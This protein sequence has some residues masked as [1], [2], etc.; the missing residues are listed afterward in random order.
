M[1]YQTSKLNV[2]RLAII[3]H[4]NDNW[5]TTNGFADEVVKPNRWVIAP[6]RLRF[7]LRQMVEQKFLT[8]EMLD[9]KTYQYRATDKGVD[10]LCEIVDSLDIFKE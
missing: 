3:K 9:G 4:G 5:F 7:A 10:L 6:E 8:V 1:G 2:L